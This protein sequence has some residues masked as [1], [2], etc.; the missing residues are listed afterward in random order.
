[1]I[2]FDAENGRDLKAVAGFIK[3]LSDAANNIADGGCDVIIT[4]GNIQLKAYDHAAL[5][6]G[7][8]DA[9]EY[10]KTELEDWC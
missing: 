9:V 4:V 7:L 10:F 1:M 8:L 3:A 5:I 6:Q 2:I